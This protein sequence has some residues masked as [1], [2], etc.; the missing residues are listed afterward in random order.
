MG[1]SSTA[2]TPLV[3]ASWWCGSAHSARAASE[4]YFGDGRGGARHGR[5]ERRRVREGVL[6]APGRRRQRGRLCPMCDCASSAEPMPAWVRGEEASTA[7]EDDSML[8][9]SLRDRLGRHRPPSPIPAPRP[10]A[11]LHA[12]P[13]AV[14]AAPPASP[15]SSRPRDSDGEDRGRAGAAAAEAHA[16]QSAQA[17]RAP[18][19]PPDPLRARCGMQRRRRA[20]PRRDRRRPRPP[21]RTSW[22]ARAPATRPA[23][24]RRTM[25]PQT[26]TPTPTQRPRRRCSR[27]R[28]TPRAAVR[29]ALK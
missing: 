3:P 4:S 21:P 22:A 19:V 14:S 25:R 24:P 26:R 13:W 5:G 10:S 16:A 8:R 2:S 9:L 7:E 15:K 18:E 23:S 27:R 6:V 12:S 17:G 29:S 28:A 20:V 1:R 11:G